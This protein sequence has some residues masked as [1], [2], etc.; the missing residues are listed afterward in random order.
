ME[1]KLWTKEPR[2]VNLPTRIPSYEE[3]RANMEALIRQAEQHMRQ[4]AM[5]T[6]YLTPPWLQGRPRDP[7][8]NPFIWPDSRKP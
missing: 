6:P 3:A 7:K 1:P 2:T 8:A 5:E 4:M